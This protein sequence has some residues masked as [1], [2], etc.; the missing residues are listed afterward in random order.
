MTTKVS[1]IH[2]K[3]GWRDTPWHT[4]FCRQQKKIFRQST[5]Q[6]QFP[7]SFHLWREMLK[8]L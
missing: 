3:N 4:K 6:P 2:C 5:H 7:K 1:Y 8:E